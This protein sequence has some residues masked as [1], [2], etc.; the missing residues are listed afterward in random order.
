VQYCY[1]DHSVAVVNSTYEAHEGMK[2]SAK[3]YN[4]DA[5]EMASRE[6][7]V[8]VPADA[9]VK[10]FDLPKAEGLST[11]FFVRLEMRDTS[12]KLVS[13]NFYWLSTK[14]DTLDWANRRDTVYTP[15][16]EFA[17]LTGLNSLAEAKVRVTR[18]FERRGGK[19]IVR[20]TLK[21]EGTAVAF[22][23]RLRLTDARGNDVEPVFWEDNYI[24]LLPGESRL[25]NGS[26]D[27]AALRGAG[28]EV[29]VSGW[30]VQT[31]IVGAS[32]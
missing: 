5:K 11:T 1:D 2:V 20:V 7:T 27:E 32:R 22:L 30:N 6:E 12:G 10:A 31:E 4:L 24:S 23:I 19:G 29:R 8:E 3:V 21:N 15:Q 25:V 16:A 9:A 26:Y 17:D 14:E 13:E 18:S 28:A